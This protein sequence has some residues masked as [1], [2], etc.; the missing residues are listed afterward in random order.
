[1]I[2]AADVS[3]KMATSLLCSTNMLA[4]GTLELFSIHIMFDNWS[5]VK[6]NVQYLTYFMKSKFREGDLYPRWLRPIHKNG[7]CILP[8]SKKLLKRRDMKALI[9]ECHTFLA[10][11]HHLR[12]VISCSFIRRALGASVMKNFLQKKSLQSKE[13]R[14][15]R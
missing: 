15:F 5:K 13:R 14:N 11:K 8:H 10:V 7:A 1:M 9:C 3:V 12:G 2:L 4:T 6:S